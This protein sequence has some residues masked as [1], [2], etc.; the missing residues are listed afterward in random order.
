MLNGM[1]TLHDSRQMNSRNELREAL[2][3]NESLRQG[4][5]NIPV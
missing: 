4:N 3:A 1:A 2:L 5:L